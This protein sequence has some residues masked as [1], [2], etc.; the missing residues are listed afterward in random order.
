MS[1]MKLPRSTFFNWKSRLKKD[2]HLDDAP[3]SGRPCKATPR[4]L[5]HLSIVAKS[6][7]RLSAV[8]LA[9]EAG[10]GVCAKTARRYLR[11]SGFSP[12][13]PLSRPFLTVKHARNR[14]KFALEHSQLAEASWSRWGFSDECSV[15]LSCGESKELVWIRPEDRL[16]QGNVKMAVQ[17]GGGSVMIWGSISAHGCGP[18]VFIDGNINAEKV[19]SSD[20]RDGK[21]KPRCFKRT[22][23]RKFCFSR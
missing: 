5:R 7:P 15:E 8:E 1:E 2:G 3:R 21:A 10:L 16:R 4:S 20:T 12:R 11:K 23:W 14:Y 19:P 9:K 17:Q 13:K 6:N 22:T 18:L